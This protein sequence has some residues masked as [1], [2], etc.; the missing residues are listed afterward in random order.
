MIT[1]V[2][3]SCVSACIRDPL[4][5]VGGMNHFMLPGSTAQRMDQ[6]GGDDCLATRYGIAAMETLINDLLKLGSRKDR[7][8]LKLFGGGNVM[9]MDVNGVGDRNV[10]FVRQFVKAEGITVVA[11]DLGEV[12]PR[13]VNYFPK[14][15]KVMVRRL[16]SLQ[17]QAV[18]DQEKNYERTVGKQQVPG[19]IELF[20]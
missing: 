3:G 15:G 4:S 10:K 12:F 7:L 11:E 18:V 5:G 16:R 9:A 19:E 1:T 20:D 13:K 2:L 14:T 8:E 6:W 17:N